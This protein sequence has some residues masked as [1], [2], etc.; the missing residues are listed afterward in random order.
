MKKLFSLF[1]ILV[2]LI[3][4]V[5][6][7]SCDGGEDPV[8]TDGETQSES[9]SLDN[10]SPTKLNG[11]TPKEAYRAA[12]NSTAF[13]TNGTTVMTMI[14]EIQSEDTQLKMSQTV[15]T[16]KDGDKVYLC[17]E[18]DGQQSEMWFDGTT[19]YNKVGAAKYKE[20]ITEDRFE[21]YRAAIDLSDAVLLEIPDALF[22]DQTFQK[23]EASGNYVVELKIVGDDLKSFLE[24]MGADAEQTILAN[25][26]FSYLLTFDPNAKLVGLSFAFSVAAEEMHSTV[27]VDLS[28]CDMGSTQVTLPE[29]ADSYLENS[30]TPAN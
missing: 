30:S 5:A 14:S 11:K 18:M 7:A 19:L 6:L 28:L 29:D 10:L 8:G 20:T 26:N 16:M 2:L 23:D 9:E 22:A 12:V 15:T 4:C 17:V 24:A 1:L 27:S 25:E 13:I 21:Q 3:S